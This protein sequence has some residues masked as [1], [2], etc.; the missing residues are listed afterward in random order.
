MREM[1][2]KEEQRIG[3]IIIF[4]HKK[5]Q[6]ITRKKILST[7]RQHQSRNL[8]FIEAIKTDMIIYLSTNLP[9]KEIE[10]RVEKILSLELKTKVKI[11]ALSFTTLIEATNRI[12]E[13]LAEKRK[14][15]KLNNNVIQI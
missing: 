2:I 13:I 10:K 5:P 14:K 3:T 11:K 1:N 15:E 6:K 8:K 4:W 9:K 12:K 7:L